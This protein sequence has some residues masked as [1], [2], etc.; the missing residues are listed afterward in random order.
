MV[1]TGIPDEIRVPLQWHTARRKEL[2]IYNV[3]RSN[4][5]TEA[6]LALLRDY[7]S[8]FAPV[9]THT[10]PMDQVQPAFE[11]LEHYSGGAGKVVIEP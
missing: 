1:V 2:V 3:R 4:H 9:V 5:E 7:P 8:R 6:A 11:M 10:F